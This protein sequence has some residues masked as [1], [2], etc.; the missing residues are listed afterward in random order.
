MQSDG[1]RM[2][3]FACAFVLVLCSAGLLQHLQLTLMKA[4]VLA[5]LQ[6]LPGQL[7]QLC[8]SATS[9]GRG[10]R[11]AATALLCPA[12]PRGARPPP[13]HLPTPSTCASPTHPAP[14]P[15]FSDME[16]RNKDKCRGWVGF[17]VKMAHRITA[18]CDILLM[19]SRFE[20]CGLNQLYAMAYG[21]GEHGGAGPLRGL[22][23]LSSC[24]PAGGLRARL[25]ALWCARPA[26]PARSL[27]C[28]VQPCWPAREHP[29]GM[30][31]ARLLRRIPASPLPLLNPPPPTTPLCSARGARRGRPARHRQALQPL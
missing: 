29:L 12:S 3:G 16:N 21:T 22:A 13:I 11:W 30:G 8:S 25:A 20:P 2:V 14:P 1:P 27:R 17:S 10:R 18:G 31:Q 7:L 5:F 23:P 4:R 15:S 19:P 6:S 26:E 28:A 24:T 9:L